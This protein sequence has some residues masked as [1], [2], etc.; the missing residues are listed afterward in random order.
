MAKR[1][2]SSSIKTKTKTNISAPAV[3]K[4]KKS[5]TVAVAT[6]TADQQQQQHS[7][8][9]LT[10]EDVFEKEEAILE[11]AKNYNQLVPLLQALKNE[12]K[13]DKEKNTN[14]N[15]NEDQ[16][17]DEGEE[18]DLVIALITCLFKIFGK[19][20]KKNQLRSFPTM[21]PAQ[22]KV[23][24][25]LGE[26]YDT[27]KNLLFTTIKT[28][29]NDTLQ[30][31][32]V[33]IIFRLAKVENA[34]YSLDEIYFPKP[35]LVGLFEAVLFANDT[36]HVDVAIEELTDKYLIE[37][38]DIRYYF[39]SLVDG[40]LVDLLVDQK[41]L[42]DNSDPEFKSLAAIA[43]VRLF[44]ILSKLSA[45]FPD[46]D[47]Q[48]N[49]FYLEVPKKYVNPTRLISSPLRLSSHKTVFQKCWLSAFKLPVSYDQY[50][51]VLQ[52]LHKSIIPNMIQP[53]MLLDFLTNAYDA[54]GPISI[55]ALNGL[56]SLMQ[57]YNLEYPNFYAKL[58]QLFDN[59]ILHVKYRSRFLRLVDVFLSSTHVAANIVASFIKKLS[60]LALYAPPAAIVAIVPFIY[61]LLKRH[62][63]CMDLIQR[64]DYDAGDDDGFMDP[65]DDNEMD[66]L[67]TNAIESSLWELETLQTHYHPNV[68]TLTRIISEQ[69]TK[70]SYN[71]EDFLDMSYSTLME[72][73]QTRR[74]KAPPALEFETF[75]RI[76]GFKR[77]D[78]GE[79]E[80][81][82]ID[83][84]VN[85]P[86]MV[87]WVF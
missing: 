43:S 81:E 40:L 82:E 31:L 51:A 46:S 75:D 53:Q 28:S 45:I 71:M 26:R 57:K 20:L 76:F 64:P 83:E 70:E 15:D 47:D 6:V 4:S 2:Q 55:L 38:D 74:L 59:S 5:T 24:E 73:E 37:Y 25:W 85:P 9:K 21:T 50:K 23:T 8:Q 60:R 27:F 32:A 7:S 14:N 77:P 56:F 11:S 16:E 35:L 17:D 13:S 63:T 84:G 52:I 87:N 12:I 33:Q 10:I 69:F 66:P 49:S 80:D 29:T 65:F 41:K 61:N 58:Y 34:H 54:G 3:K 79:V 86:M 48:V 72:A 18:E 78:Q 42:Q 36:A 19:L 22:Q 44:D 1:K 30:A 68:A 39:M 62:P 67:Y